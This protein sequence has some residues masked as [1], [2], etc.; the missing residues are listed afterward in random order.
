MKYKELLK[1]L[2]GDLKELGETL[3]GAVRGLGILGYGS[4]VSFIKIPVQGTER[5]T[6]G[7]LPRHRIQGL[8]RTINELEDKYV[9]ILEC[10][11]LNH[12]SYRDIQN[13]GICPKSTVGRWLDEAKE[14]LI[15]LRYWE[16]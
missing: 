9:R 15:E 4:T 7:Y 13:Y 10:I 5:L 1:R 8:H 12:M 16:N 11:Y 6:P 3:N 2:E 14:K